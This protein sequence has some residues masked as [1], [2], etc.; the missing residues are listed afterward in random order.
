MNNQL[1]ILSTLLVGALV[2]VPA[3]ATAA[4]PDLC[5]EVVLTADGSPYEDS[6][7]QRVSR[8]CEPHVDPPVW[9]SS[10]CCAVGDEADCVPT[11]SRGSCSVGMKFWCDYGEQVGE[12]VACYQPAP[13]ACDLGACLEVENPNGM[14]VFT[15][16]IWLCCEDYGADVECVHAGMTDWGE[17]P[18][19]DCGGFLAMCDW[20]VTNADGTVDCFN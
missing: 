12:G 6:T 7:G 10:M 5:D 16:A 11:N 3:R 15:D 1:T 18:D 8:W 13:S 20:G 9:N 19:S 14:S 4:P 2:V 17:Y